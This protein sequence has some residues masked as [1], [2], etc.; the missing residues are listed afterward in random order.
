[1]DAHQI[2]QHLTDLVL[3]GREDVAIEELL[4]ISNS[5]GKQFKDSIAAL[6]ERYRR[7]EQEKATGAI[8]KEIV[9]T[10]SSKISQALMVLIEQ[11]T[12]DLDDE[13]HL[14]DLNSLLADIDQAS[15][16]AD[17]HSGK[18]R[19]TMRGLAIAVP[20]LLAVVLAILAFN[21]TFSNSKPS[22]ETVSSW[23]GT[24]QHEMESSGE[25]KIT[26]TLSFSVTGEEN[27]MTG[28]SQTT[29][30][31]GSE[32]VIRLSSIVFT[33]G[34]KIMDGQWQAENVQSL[35]GTFRFNLEGSDRFEGYYTV[36]DQE[37]EF[38]WNGSKSNAL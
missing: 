1:M 11:V 25:G 14:Q 18:G 31:D 16:G 8:N 22:Q 4:A 23:T 17:T 10:T 33:R 34:G 6:S 36:G 20:V 32:T 27:E 7:F 5:A 12:E 38:Y 19:K 37:G 28:T 3:D 29:F 9:R 30:P 15:A 26:G 2:K 24:W 21:G 35:H 13:S